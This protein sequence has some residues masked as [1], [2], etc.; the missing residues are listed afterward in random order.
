MLPEDREDGWEG[1]RIKM[2]AKA[3]FFI[4]LLFNR[5]LYRYGRAWD[6][7]E[8][9]SCSLIA[10]YCSTS[11]S[12]GGA[13]TCK[14][15]SKGSAEMQR[16]LDNELASFPEGLPEWN[17]V[18]PPFIQLSWLVKTSPSVTFLWWKKKGKNGIVKEYDIIC[19][20]KWTV[21][22]SCLTIPLPI[23]STELGASF[24]EGHLPKTRQGTESV[25]KSSWPAAGHHSG[26]MGIQPISVTPTHSPWKSWRA[27]N[28]F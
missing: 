12:A 2:Y 13:H 1:W 5:N 25:L 10:T 8:R 23:E 22:I 24:D 9:L 27:K 3:S 6:Q 4:Y 19:I 16:S 18:S 20:Y 14:A 21:N 15:G 28:K 7:A 26:A 17:G 11:R